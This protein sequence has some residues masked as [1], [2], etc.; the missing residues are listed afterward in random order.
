MYYIK[1]T[2][3]TT[4]SIPNFFKD[5]MKEVCMLIILIQRKSVKNDH[6]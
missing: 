5:L 2:R 4:E 6:P 3:F 1:W